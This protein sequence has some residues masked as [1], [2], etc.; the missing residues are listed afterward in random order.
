MHTAT[1]GRK[2]LP[3]ELVDMV[4]DHLYTDKTTLAACTLVRRDW[5]AASRLHLFNDVI[6]FHERTERPFGRFTDFLRE[7]PAIGSLIKILCINGY[8]PKDSRQGLMW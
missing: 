2:T 8:N 1:T 6:V 7:K 4:I 3:P 5:L